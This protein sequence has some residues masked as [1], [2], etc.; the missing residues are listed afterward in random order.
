MT[1]SGVFD[2]EF[3]SGTECCWTT[4]PVAGPGPPRLIYPR[5]MPRDEEGSQHGRKVAGRP[6][7]HDSHAPT[8]INRQGHGGPNSSNWMTMVHHFDGGS[9]SCSSPAQQV[10]EFACAPS[11][12]RN[13]LRLPAQMVAF[14]HS[15]VPSPCSRCYRPTRT[16]G[17]AWNSLRIQQPCVPSSPIP[18]WAAAS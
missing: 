9:R 15:R 11:L 3:P 1:E 12:A 14:Y 17:P 2:D 7:F 10:C 6:C 8:G 16:P 4:I 13:L 18:R 5:G